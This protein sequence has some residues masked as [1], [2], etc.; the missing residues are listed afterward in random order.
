MILLYAINKIRFLPAPNEYN[1]I[2]VGLKA[3]GLKQNLLT[4][5]ICVTS[6]LFSFPHRLKLTSIPALNGIV[7]S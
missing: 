5:E 4:S 6:H 3:V 7:R 2:V 1:L